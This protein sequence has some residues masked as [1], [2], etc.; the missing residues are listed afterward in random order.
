MHSKSLHQIPRQSRHSDILKNVLVNCISLTF[1]LKYKYVKAHQDD[2]NDYGI[3]ERLSQLKY[4]CNGL[5][6][7][8]IWGLAGE[9]YPHHKHISLEPLAI[10]I[11]RDKLT[12]YMARELRLW[13]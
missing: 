2:H 4:L 1:G 3:L 5:V 11:G 13:V 7:D 9:E 12:T 8:V 6:K 10:F